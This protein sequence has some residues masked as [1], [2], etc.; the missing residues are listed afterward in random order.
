MNYKTKCKLMD[1]RDYV[2][3]SI[4]NMEFTQTLIPY[5]AK[6]PDLIEQIEKAVARV[7][8]K[9]TLYTADS[10]KLVLDGESVHLIVTSPPYWTLKKYPDGKGQ[11]GA[12]ANYKEFLNELDK[13][14]ARCY[15]ALVP[16]GR[17]I[18]VV[19]DVC[20]SRKANGKHSVIPL[21]SSI[22]E[23]LTKRGFANLAPIIWHKIANA[24]YE[25]NGN[26]KFLGKPY[27]PGGIIK[28][29]IEYI[30]MARKPGSYRKVT[31][32]ARLLSAISDS[33]H[34]KWFQQIWTGIVGESTRIH[35]APFPLQ[36]AERLVR[37]F[38]FI[39]DVVLDPFMGTG[40]TNL[41]AANWG[42][43]SIGIDIDASYCEIALNRLNK[44]ANTVEGICIEVGNKHVGSKR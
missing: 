41:A 32:E 43:N 19:G 9:H 6:N 26:N 4:N 8:T 34:K 29:D 42:R 16:G 7:P 5:I 1:L 31:T 30:I 23:R 37:M 39:G 22:Q 24:K 21:H 10:R 3:S 40:T 44:R 17:L 18:C 33:N 38:S 12:V 25:A 28:N 35:P 14:W 13:V 20:L 15:R 2:P 27:E 11:L 36:L